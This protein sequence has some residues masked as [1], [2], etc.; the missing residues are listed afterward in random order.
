[1][2]AMQDDKCDGADGCVFTPDD[3]KCDDEVDCT[4]DT[5]TGSGCEN[6]PDATKCDKPPTCKVA[7]G[8]V[9]DNDG[10][11]QYKDKDCDGVHT[12]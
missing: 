8:A 11:C 10:G 4:V 1:M 6:V 12:A 2:P 5:C 3:G 7:A 9:C